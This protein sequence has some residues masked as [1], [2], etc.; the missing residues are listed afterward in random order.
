MHIAHGVLQAACSRRSCHGRTQGERKLQH[1]MLQ[2]WDISVGPREVLMLT[3][4]PASLR[5]TKSTPALDLRL[6]SM[7]AK[8]GM[9]R[10]KCCKGCMIWGQCL[11]E[12]TAGVPEQACMTQ[13]VHVLRLG[14]WCQNSLP[15]LFG[16]PF[17]PNLLSRF[18]TACPTS[19][20]HC[21]FVG[22]IAVAD[23][24]FPVLEI[25]VCLHIP[26]RGLDVWFLI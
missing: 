11:P 9:T 18:P 12:A 1:S 23:G 17:L 6:G 2:K 22:R 5:E 15:C 16:N 14:H 7:D 13:V 20:S 24:P 3:W 4:E 8:F 25:T 10:V 26:D 19:R 21:C